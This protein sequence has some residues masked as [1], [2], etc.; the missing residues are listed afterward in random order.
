MIEKVGRYR[1]DAESYL[2]DFQGRVTI[3][4]LGNYLLHA[5]SAHAGGRGFGYEEMTERRTAWVLSR[6]AIEVADYPRLAGEI[7][8][9]T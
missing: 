4:L 3:P 5:A 7:T 9:D 2:L 6:L 1:F 8:V